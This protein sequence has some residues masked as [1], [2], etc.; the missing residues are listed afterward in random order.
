MCLTWPS[1]AI[2]LQMVTQGTSLFLYCLT[3]ILNTWPPRL[4][5]NKSKVWI[6]KQGLQID[7]ETACIIFIQNPL[8]KTESD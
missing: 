3:G 8:T 7:P 2:T 4:L 1:G 5:K 6:N